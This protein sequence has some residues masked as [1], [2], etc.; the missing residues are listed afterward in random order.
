MN[1]KKNLELARKAFPN[2]EE[3][4]VA[5]MLGLEKGWD[6][7]EEEM[8]KDAVET[9]VKGYVNGRG[10]YIETDIPLGIDVNEDDKVKLIIIK[11]E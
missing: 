7:R 3:K 1:A 5:Y 8:M 10:I 4:R 2:D 9:T 11:E 6:I